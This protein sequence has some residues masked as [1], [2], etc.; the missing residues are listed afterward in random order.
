MKWILLPLQVLPSV[1]EISCLTRF[2]PSW[3]RDIADVF[4]RHLVL[5]IAIT[6]VS[7]P[8]A[9]RA[10]HTPG[11][12]T[13]Y[14]PDHPHEGGTVIIPILQMRK[15]KLREAKAVTRMG[16]QKARFPTWVCLAPK[17]YSPL[18]GQ[19]GKLTQTFSLPTVSPPR[20]WQSWVERDV[21]VL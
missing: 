11:L 15:C 3:A 7:H 16:S 1:F 10:Q 2:E 20:H 13:C 9:L 8:V 21:W 6:W 14:L 5:M 4:L 18:G 12:W 19:V 17:P